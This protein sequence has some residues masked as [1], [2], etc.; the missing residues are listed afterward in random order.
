MI[1]WGWNQ[2]SQLGRAGPESVPSK[3]EGLETEKPVSVCGGRAHSAALTAAG[4]VWVWGCGKNGRLGLGSSI[5][6]PEP[7]FLDSLEGRRVSQVV[8][9]F[10]HSL[11]LVDGE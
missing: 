7:A 11:V 8:A 3:L 2:S 4:E 1:T 9:G 6:E 10:D 5:D